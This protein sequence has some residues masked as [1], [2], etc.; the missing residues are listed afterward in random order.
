MLQQGAIA[1]NLR[2]L[3][4]CFTNIKV[5]TI[6]PVVDFQ[7]VNEV[8]DTNKCSLPVLSVLRMSLGL[9]NKNF[10]SIA[11]LSGY[12]QVPLAPESRKFTVI[13]K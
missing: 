3:H 10:T 9:G 7:E 12:C 1:S 2:E 4:P 6:L 13:S 11:L 5:Q 8:M